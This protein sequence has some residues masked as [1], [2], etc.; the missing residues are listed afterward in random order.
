VSER[1]APVMSSNA[2][3]FSRYAGVAAIGLG[4]AAQ[5]LICG[6]QTN[7]AGGWLYVLAIAI[8]LFGS[9][10]ERLDAATA[11]N[12]DAGTDQIITLILLLVA[13]AL[14]L[15]LLTEHPGVFGDEGERGMEARHILEGARPPVAGYGWW[16]VPNLYFYFIA[17]F[18]KVAGDGLF[19]LRLSSVTCGVASVFFVA[20]T[21]R[22]LWGPRAGWIAGTLM[23]VSPVALQFSRLAGE[24]GPTVA[25]WAAGFFFLFRAL[26]EE[27]PRNALAAGALLGGSLYFYASARLLL[28]IVPVI[29]LGLLVSRPSQVG[30]RIVGG[31]TLAF[32]LSVLPLAATSWK[33]REEFVG[34]YRETSIFSPQ[35]RPIA[36]HEAGVTY[37]ESWRDET[38]LQ[39][40]S[41]HL[42]SWSRVLLHQLRL[43]VEVLFRRGD[44][45]VFYQPGV[46]LGSLLS[47]L[48]APL[49]LLGLVWGVRHL[50]DLRFAIL[51]IWFWGGVLGP[52]LTI[53]TPSVQRFAGAWP[54][55]MLFPAAL[56]DH[57]ASP[58]T[59]TGFRR[60]MAAVP[61]IVIGSIAVMDTREYFFVYRSL[62]PYGEATAQARYVAALDSRYKVYE[63][64]VDGVRQSDVFLGYGPTRFLARDVEG[65][66]VGALPSRLPIVDE[67]GKG[68]VFLVYP[69]NAVFLPMLRLFYPD[70]IQDVVADRAA[71]RFTTYRVEARTLAQRRN[72]QASYTSFD[73]VRIERAE[74]NLGTVMSDGEP[75]RGPEGLSYPARANWHG[76]FLCPI[77]GPRKVTLAGSGDAK[78]WVDRRMITREVGAPNSAKSVDLLLAR[79][80][81]EVRLE[82]TL[83]GRSGR[84]TVGFPKPVDSK[85]LFCCPVG[86]FSGEVWNR[87]G[88]FESLPSRAPDVFRADPFLGFRYLQDDPSFPGSPFTARWRATVNAPRPGSYLL[89][90]RSNGR[91]RLLLD[92]QVRLE[93]PA[94]GELTILTEL[95]SGPH[96]LEI[97][98]AWTT[99][100]PYLEL[101]WNP[102]GESEELITPNSFGVFE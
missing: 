52:A 87:G 48:L 11:A 6:D 70:G 51:N 41:R 94:K 46:H 69:S 33:Y 92:G 38:T 93:V 76:A 64:G 95:N 101:T 44:P 47:P 9:I 35:N 79:G 43:T 72:T 25:L 89:G 60:L 74:P 13:A 62:A 84:I 12:V 18:L 80:L 96:S 78:V 68:V 102:P 82:G 55:L 10:G 17:V 66:D 7:A 85:F 54:A 77:S 23:A 45:T 86:V 34:R 90:L 100:R 65:V 15:V 57:I 63:L 4:I 30:R 75:W 58:V 81:H 67:N 71:T 50:C 98:Y 39:T 36:F 32:I 42:G 29:A 2:G 1:L 27:R 5:M 20:R 91:S 61:A 26:L 31:L 73:G 99:G 53:N 8:L 22:L 83:G 49:A 97:R 28:L 37:S 88:D 21:G 40:L 16:G 3:G 56:L 19:G 14:R 24:S 59:A